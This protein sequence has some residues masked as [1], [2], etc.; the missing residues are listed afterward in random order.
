MLRRTVN[1]NHEK[2]LLYVKKGPS[3]LYLYFFCFLSFLLSL[4]FTRLPTLLRTPKTIF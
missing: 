3:P 2:P 1:S 4:L